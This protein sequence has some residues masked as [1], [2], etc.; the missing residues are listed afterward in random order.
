MGRLSGK[1]ALVT[2]ASQ[3]I[4]LGIARL[5]AS[6]G[7]SLVVTGR[8]AP[9]LMGVIP[10]L[11]AL[12]AKVV[13]CAGDGGVRANAEKAVKAALDAFGRLDVLVN[14]AQALTPGVPLEALDEAQIRMT[15]DT[16]F[17]ATLWHMLAALPHLKQSNGSI[18]NLGSREGIVGGAGYGIYGA[19]KEAI[20]GLSRTAARE[21]GK[22]GIRINTI[23]P[24]A[25]SPAA[26][27]YFREHPEDKQIYLKDICLDRFGDPET[28]IAPAVLFLATEDSRYVTG[29][30]LN[31][32]GGQVML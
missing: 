20:R 24:A 25:W 8:K 29:Q 5:F 30:T 23:A 28:D 32:D 12:G 7:A 11:E 13:A 17:Y 31:V 26:D 22:Y 15:V 19:G 4:G 18:I 16:G 6:E 3:G 21:W 27:A 1:V 14:N 9:K 2:G 10:E